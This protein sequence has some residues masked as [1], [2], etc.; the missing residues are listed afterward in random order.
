[1]LPPESISSASTTNHNLNATEIADRGAFT[2]PNP[3]SALTGGPTCARPAEILD[4]QIQ[5][6]SRLKLAL[7]ARIT[8]MCRRGP[9]SRNFS[10]AVV[11]L[12]DGRTLLKQ[13]AS[14]K[15]L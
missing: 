2:G 9:E 10:D 6:V 1:L 3:T 11:T 13:F 4:R 14:L 12:A 8:S 5:N 15:Q 7:K